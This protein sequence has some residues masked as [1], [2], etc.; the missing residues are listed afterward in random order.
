MVGLVSDITA[1]QAVEEAL[2][3]IA[4]GS[5]RAERGG[6]PAQARAQLRRGAGRARGFVCECSDYPTTRVR[7]LARWKAGELRA[8][9]SSISRAPR[10][11]T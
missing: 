10:A 8:A 6:M 1:A 7:M 3:E 11:K 9:S 5:V 2:V 4:E